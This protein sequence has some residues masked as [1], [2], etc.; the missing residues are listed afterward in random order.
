MEHV[1]IEPIFVFNKD[2]YG[3][4]IFLAGP[5]Y[6]KLSVWDVFM[7]YDKSFALSYEEASLYLKN[8]PPKQTLKIKKRKNNEK[9]N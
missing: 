6:S 1:S 9:S 4:I 5:L 2:N 3:N 8:L 7:K